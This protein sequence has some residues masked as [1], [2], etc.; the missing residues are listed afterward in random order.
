[1]INSCSEF[2]E[3]LADLAEGRATP[4]AEAHVAEC[5]SCREKVAQLRTIVSVT[6]WAGGSAPAEWVDRAI[7]IM[8]PAKRT[9]FATLL[10]TSFA[11]GSARSA[12]QD[13]QLQVEAE[14]IPFRFSYSNSG[15]GWF[16]LGRV[17][18]EF[19]L[20]THKQGEQ[21]PDEQGGFKFHAMN[22]KDTAFDLVAA[23]R[24]IH[25]PAATDLS[26]DIAHG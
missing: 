21:W 3:A 15:R 26:Y 1:M 6:R 13:F 25:V 12:T 9:I 19:D 18:Q 14:G 7:D 4:A 5:E 8:K 2:T 16:V 10:R 24:V 22:L 11:Q 17:P 23:D 20:V